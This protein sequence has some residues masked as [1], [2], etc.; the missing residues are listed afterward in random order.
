MPFFKVVA[1]VV[2]KTSYVVEARDE[3]E[4][5]Y[6]VGKNPGYDIVAGDIVNAEP[7]MGIK[8]PLVI[9]YQLLKVTATKEKGS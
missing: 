4:A 3:D 7:G 5:C 9:G 1:E 2:V 8:T 6:R